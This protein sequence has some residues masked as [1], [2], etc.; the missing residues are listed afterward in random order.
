LISGRSMSQS[1]ARTP[2]ASR[3]LPVV[4][5]FYGQPSEHTLRDDEGA[6]H[7]IPQGAGGEQ[8]DPFTPALFALGQHPALD[9]LRAV[10]RDGEH[11]FGCFDDIYF[12]SRPEQAK[13]IFDL[14]AAASWRHARTRVNLGKTKVPG[15][16]PGCSRPGSRL[17]VLRSTLFGWA[18]RRS[19]RRSK[20]WS[21]LAQP[22]GIW[23]SWR[24]PCGGEAGPR[25]SIP[26][27]RQDPRFASGLAPSTIAKACLRF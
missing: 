17:W 10:L 9:E 18:T 14:V 5:M 22:S 1:L 3:L 15:T 20:G 21:P 24:L 16:G 26:K 19:P 25:R 4:R 13:T 23:I 2:R 7:S 12:V 8:R 11:A 6:A 27:V